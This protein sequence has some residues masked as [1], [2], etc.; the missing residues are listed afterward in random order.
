MNKVILMGFLGKDP[1]IKHTS[2]GTLANFSMA[3]S[4]KWKDKQGQWQEKTEWHRITAWGG[5]AETASKLSKGMKVLVDGE[6]Q[7]RSWENSE[8]KKQY[9]TEV[10]ARSIEF[11]EPKQSKPKPQQSFGPEPSFDSNEEIPF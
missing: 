1:E 6:L 3:T 5:T 9:V 7:T 4:K 11:A 8:G 2:G 10:L